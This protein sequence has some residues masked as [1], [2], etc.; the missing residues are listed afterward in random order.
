MQ[1]LAASESVAP[2]VCGAAVAEASLL[3]GETWR[4]LLEVD[5]DICGNDGVLTVLGMLGGYLFWPLIGFTPATLA[6]SRHLSNSSTLGN[7]LGL[8]EVRRN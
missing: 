2:F 8:P 4:G 3:P 6:F 1:E 5:T 7:R